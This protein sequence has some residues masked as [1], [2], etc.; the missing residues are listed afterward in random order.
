[1]TSKITNEF[2]DGSKSYFTL[3]RGFFTRNSYYRDCLY[4]QF[5]PYSIKLWAV[6]ELFRFIPKVSHR[7]FQSL[8]FSLVE[9][10]F[11]KDLQDSHYFLLYFQ[12]RSNQ[13]FNLDYFLQSNSFLYLVKVR[14]VALK[15]LN[16]TSQVQKSIMY[17][18]TTSKYRYKTIKNNINRK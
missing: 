12:P 13:S 14:G 2:V 3:F 1:M 10:V 18:R 15:N 8:K 7:M 6:F 5:Q 9:S 4:R 11:A 17:L 16:K